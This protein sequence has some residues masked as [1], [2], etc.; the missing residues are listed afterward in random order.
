M[1]AGSTMEIIK[2]TDEYQLKRC[3]ELR[4]RVFIEE[5]N[6]PAEEEIDEHDR[7][8]DPIAMHYLFL[9][10]DEIIG[11]IRCMKKADG[12]LKIGRVAVAMEQRKKGYGQT[13]MTMV[14]DLHP[15]YR[16]FV[17]DAQTHAI[18][19]YLRCGY[20]E[21]GDVFMD[22]GIPHRHMEKANGNFR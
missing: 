15:E 5:Q 13:M 21:C 19:F 3:M 20:T 16:R 10:D 22:A 11:T 17:L 18:P 12:I 9:V 7:L 14:E 6:V 8:G 2:V 1:K 4:R